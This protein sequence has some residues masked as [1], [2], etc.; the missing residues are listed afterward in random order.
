MSVVAGKV[1]VSFV[2]SKLQ[3]MPARFRHCPQQG[4]PRDS[5]SR[6]TIVLGSGGG[7]FLLGKLCLG[8]VYQLLLA[9]VLVLLVLG[10]L[11]SGNRPLVGKSI[12]N[13][14]SKRRPPKNLKIVSV[15][16]LSVLFMGKPR[17]AGP[18]A[19]WKGQERWTTARWDSTMGQGQ[20]VGLVDEH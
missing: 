18:I 6:H 5:D 16:I 17:I 13:T 9:L 11:R 10:P 4:P 7:S 1:R 3:H 14:D 15:S 8:L 12:E 20:G 2:P 19:S